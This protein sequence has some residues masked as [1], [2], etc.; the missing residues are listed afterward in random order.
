MRSLW[1]WG[2]TDER[3]PQTKLWGTPALEVRRWG[4]T[5]NDYDFKRYDGATN[6]VIIE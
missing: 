1:K 4:R 6:S 3:S 5:I 2:Q